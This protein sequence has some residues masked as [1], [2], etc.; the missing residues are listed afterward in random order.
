V[1]ALRALSADPGA[2]REETLISCVAIIGRGMVLLVLAHLS[3][4]SA[5]WPRPGYVLVLGLLFLGTL[6]Q[7]ARMLLAGPGTR[8]TVPGWMAAG[9][10]E[11]PA[12]PAEPAPARIT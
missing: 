5:H 8:L 6:G 12:K 9:A 4:V 10:G 1:A 11:H 2:R 7:A 3:M